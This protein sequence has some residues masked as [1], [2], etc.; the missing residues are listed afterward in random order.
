M[1]LECL[2]GAHWADAIGDCL[3]YHPRDWSQD[4][5][6]AWLWGVING[7]SEETICRLAEKFQWSEAAVEELRCQRQA[8][9]CAALSPQ[10]K[11]LKQ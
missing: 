2:K 8:F 9:I 5:R 3:S 11:K 1:E 6:D 7:W 4:H 10:L